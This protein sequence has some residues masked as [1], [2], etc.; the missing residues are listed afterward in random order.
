[1]I[2]KRLR[3]SEPAALSI[4]TACPAEF[5]LKVIAG[6]WKVLIVWH[7][8]SGTRRF[9]ELR[10]CLPA[11][12]P[13][14]LTRQLRELEADRVLLRKIY[15]EIPPRV[16]YTLTPRGRTLNAIVNEMCKWGRGQR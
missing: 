11:I 5:T 16:E 2:P 8:M 3:Q 6:K 10:K 9:N 14:M 15:A 13:R 1:M 4:D 7:L 12:T